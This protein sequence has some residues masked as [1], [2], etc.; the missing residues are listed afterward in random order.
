MT[1]TQSSFRLNRL[2]GGAIAVLAIVLIV[3][4]A[5][6][7][8]ADRRDAANVTRLFGGP[9]GLKPILAPDKVEAFRVA[10]R[11]RQGDEPPSAFG[12]AEIVS[13]PVRV[14]D[15]TA[16]DLAE[17]LKSPGTYSWDSA[18]GCIFDPG[19]A[20]RFGGKSS[21][22]EVVFCFSC[23]ELQI[24]QGGQRVGAEDFDK[25]RGRLASIMKRVFPDDGE[26]EKL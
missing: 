14:D 10:R 13:G 16:R 7:Y 4:G 20:F 26:I 5:A 24:Y 6:A 21:I 9:A 3:G 8:L 11:T 1:T 17:I 15:N 25:A 22:I 23:N 18:K 12:G 19:V 2:L